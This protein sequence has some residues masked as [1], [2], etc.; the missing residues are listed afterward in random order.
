M[1]TVIQRL[2]TLKWR[3]SPGRQTRKSTPVHVRAR[4]IANHQMR[5]PNLLVGRDIVTKGCVRSCRE[6]PSSAVFQIIARDETGSATIATNDL[7]LPPPV[8]L[9]TQDSENVAFAERK[10]F[11]NSG[12]VHVHGA[13]WVHSQDVLHLYGMKGT[14]KTYNSE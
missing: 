6:W 8:V 14:T 7:S 13:S 2:Y 4:A 1:K 11:R 9:Q 10:L 3:V 5:H 12:L